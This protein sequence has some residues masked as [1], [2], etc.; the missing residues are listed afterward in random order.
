MTNS[1]L[2]YLFSSNIRPL[3]EQD[4]LDVVA[5]PA[6]GLYQFR[7]ERRWVDPVGRER[8]LSLP[9]GTPVLV[10][11]SLQQP[12]RYHDPVF[13]PVRRGTVK[14]TFAQG[15]TLF[16]EFLLGDLVA[17]PEPAKGESGRPDFAAETHAYRSYLERKEAP[18]PYSFSAGLGPNILSAPE[19][20][21][22]LSSDQVTLFERTTKYLQ[23]TLS[24][25][26]ARFLRFLCL[27]PRGKQLDL[28]PDADGVFSLEGGT[29][30]TLELF[31][32]QP[33]E[34]T[35]ED[36]F[37]VSVDGGIIRII[38]RAGFDIGSR[39]DR[40]AIAFHAA[41]SDKYEAR[42]TVL[43]IE[44]TEGV[45]GPQLRL[46]LRVEPPSTKLLAGSVLSTAALAVLGSASLLP[47]STALKAVLIV[48]AV[49]T[50]AALSFFGLYVSALAGFK[51]PGLASGTGSSAGGG[52]TTSA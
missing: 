40:I 16:V 46:H 5:A 36:S 51:F 10:H 8:W 25:S 21:L 23:P 32:H 15:E 35:S 42:E 17:L 12:A 6:G 37:T 33:V 50:I 2:L 52:T 11:F 38:G 24:F 44:P 41:Q 34:V 48:T 9:Q 30:Y 27:G 43:V 19:S 1:P 49:V 20:P 4:I 14:R 45:K 7:Y 39:Y 18:R 47:V 26:D 3:Y 31:H 29:T 28:A 22:D 13:F